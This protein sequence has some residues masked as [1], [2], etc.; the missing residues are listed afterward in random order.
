MRQVDVI[1]TSG[2]CRR[3]RHAGFGFFAAKT[4]A[5]RQA[6]QNSLIAHLC[7]AVGLYIAA[8][9]YNALFVG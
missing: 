5:P 8:W 4:P 1:N 2:C 3:D 9:I 7:F 6:I